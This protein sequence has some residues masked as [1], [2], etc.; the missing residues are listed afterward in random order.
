MLA[1]Q[2]QQSSTC[3]LLPGLMGI[4]SS[5]LRVPWT[6]EVELRTLDCEGGEVRGWVEGAGP[7]RRHAVLASLCHHEVVLLLLLV[8]AEHTVG[9][10][11]CTLSVE[12]ATV[13]SSLWWMLPPAGVREVHRMAVILCTECS[14]S[15][16]QPA[17]TRDLFCH[18]QLFAEDKQ[19]W[20]LV[21]SHSPDD[22]SEEAEMDFVIVSMLQVVAKNAAF[23]VLGQ[24]YRLADVRA[25]INSAAGR[26]VDGHLKQQLDNH[27]CSSYCHLIP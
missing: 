3:P 19:G 15:I 9:L 17:H 6:D 10:H 7:S 16:K 5:E 13:S 20:S 12:L 11:K 8:E 21:C 24:P 4:L 14:C 1:G 27:A 22:S 23:H 25:Q 18:R 2:E 26:A